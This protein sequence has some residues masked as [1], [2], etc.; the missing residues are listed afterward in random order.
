[1]PFL[2]LWSN[3][4][5]YYLATVFLT[6]RVVSLVAIVDSSCTIE[7]IVNS[8]TSFALIES[9]LASNVVLDESLIHILVSIVP[10]ARVSFDE[11]LAPIVKKSITRITFN[12]SIIRLAFV[13]ISD[14]SSIV[15]L[16]E[17]LVRASFANMQPKNW[18]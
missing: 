1:M 9:S 7:G 8:S 13:D 17:S 16:S 6:N 18:P 12:E 5:V 11:S 2:I 10:I 14:S 3:Q 15:I 4:T